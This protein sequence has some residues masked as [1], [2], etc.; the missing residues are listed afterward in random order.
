MRNCFRTILSAFLLLTAVMPVSARK[1]KSAAPLKVGTY[2]LMTSD[3]RKKVILRDSTVSTQRYWRHSA[4]AV[5]QMIDELD[6]DIIGLQEICDS[7]WGVKGENGIQD[8]VKKRYEWILYPNSSKGKISYD[9]AIAYKTDRLRCI[10]SGIFWTGGYP[11]EP[12]SERRGAAR[13][14]TWALMKDIKSG[15]KFYFLSVHIH[16]KQHKG[17]NLQNFFSYSD[18]LIPDNIPSLL[19]GDMNSGSRLPEFATPLKASRWVDAYDKLLAAGAVPKEDKCGTMNSKNETSIG[20][21]RLDHILCHGFEASD[22]H[23]DRRKFPTTDGTLH[24]PS[25]HLPVTCIVRFK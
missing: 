10:K 13:P 6:C 19:V 23:I 24:Y 22:V 18:K 17:F 20:K 8:Q 14:C 2:N 4:Q 12:R 25:D 3:S 15:K 7:I 1:A 11:N 9:T 21:Y 5:A 16:F